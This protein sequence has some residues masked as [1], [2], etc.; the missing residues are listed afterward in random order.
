[1][2]QLRLPRVRYLTGEPGVE[3]IVDFW[4]MRADSWLDRAP[5]AEVD[6]VR[7]VA[8]DEA[9]ALLTYA[10]DRG[11][12]RAFLDRPPVHGLIALVRHAHAGERGTWTGP[13]MERPLDAAGAGNARMLSAVLACLAPRRIVSARP[14]RCR[15]TVQPLADAVGI[16][17]ETDGRFD[18]HADP[19][20]AFAALRELAQPGHPVVVCSQ[21]K[22]IP[23]LLEAVTGRAHQ[24][25]RTGKGTGWVVSFGPDGAAAVDYLD[26]SPDGDRVEA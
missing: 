17:V 16:G 26:P 5:D 21:G 7:W 8:A 1:V 6:Q 9:A 12:V 20:Q 22:L 19:A 2:P 4:S 24:Y 3:K 18:E 25:F 14:L 13:D 15:Q 23:P 11:V 10:H